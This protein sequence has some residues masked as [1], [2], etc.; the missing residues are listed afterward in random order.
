MIKTEGLR[1]VVGNRCLALGDDSPRAFQITG[2]NIK[3][4]LL[5]KV[6]HSFAGMVHKVKNSPDN[7]DGLV[8]YQA[9]NQAAANHR[10]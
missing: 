7:P 1:Q 3:P 8:Q 9:F 5:Y 6:I 10:K 4:D 2:A